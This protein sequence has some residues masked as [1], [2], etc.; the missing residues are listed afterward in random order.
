LIGH[1][2][3]EIFTDEGIAT[4]MERMRQRQEDE[5]K[6]IYEVYST[7]E[8]Q[9]KCKDGSLIWGEIISKPDLD[10]NKNIIGY[11]GISRDVT[12]RK[13][14]Q[15]KIK[16]LAF[17]D[18]LTKL[19]NRRLLHD[20]LKLTL[21][22]SKRSK[23]YSAIIYLDLDNFK[24]LNDTYGHSAG[25]LLLV[26]AANRLKSCVR[27]IDTVARVGCDEFV[28]I[29]NE[30]SEEKEKS[31]SEANIIAHKILAALSVTY[32][33]NIE[34]DNTLTIEHHCTASIGVLV[35]KANGDNEEN[36]F[37]HAD[38]AM[39]A[40]KEAGRNRIRFYD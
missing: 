35:F 8:I 7:L 30:L 14:M 22:S 28:V 38:A 15:D 21:H 27:E 29:L 34:S 32:S 20:R 13:E 33:F 1:H 40:A 3:F 5:K 16:E 24:P 18:P 19:P 17:Y 2:I 23:K 9:H 36:L 12:E 37:K 10:E 6:G 4:A 25:D 26:E 31:T 11:H 39:Y